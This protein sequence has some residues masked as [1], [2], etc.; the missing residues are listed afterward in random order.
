ME[1]E[2]PMWTKEELLGLIKNFWN[3][4]SYKRP[5]HPITNFLGSLGVNHPAMIPLRK[6][7][8]IVTLIGNDL[9]NIGPGAVEIAMAFLAGDPKR[10]VTL[11]PTKLVN[12]GKVFAA[13]AKHGKDFA[14]AVAEL[15]GKRPRKQ[16]GKKV[17]RWPWQKQEQPIEEEDAWTGF[18]DLHTS[19][20]QAQQKQSLWEG[21]S[22]KAHDGRQ[23]IYSFFKEH[24]EEFELEAEAAAGMALLTMMQPDTQNYRKAV[25]AALAK[26]AA[27]RQT[28]IGV[29]WR[30]VVHKYGITVVEM[31]FTGNPD[32]AKR[33]DHIA[34]VSIEGEEGTHEVYKDMTCFYIPLQ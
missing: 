3:T 33:G 2:L 4:P 7:E 23:A 9:D 24:N 28:L 22:Q 25:N 8:E 6:I 10:L 21:L 12:T 1:F 29:N 32:R 15:N 27:K 18:G 13:M 31:H 17:F 30:T 16:K 5:K 19:L 14:S 34:T 20:Q 11:D 26:Q